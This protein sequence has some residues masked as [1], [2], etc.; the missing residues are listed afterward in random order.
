MPPYMVVSGDGGGGD[1]LSA[2]RGRIFYP[3]VSQGKDQS[4]ETLMNFT[5]SISSLAAVRRFEK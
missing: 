3:R 2:G 4:F 1:I 5:W